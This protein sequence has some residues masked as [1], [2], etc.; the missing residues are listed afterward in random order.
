MLPHLLSEPLRCPELVIAPALG[1]AQSCTSQPLHYQKCVRRLLTED[2]IQIPPEY[3]QL[4]SP[5]LYF[6]SWP[7]QTSRAETLGHQDRH[8]RQA[9][10]LHAST[11]RP[12]T[13]SDPHRRRRPGRILRPERPPWPFPQARRPSLYNC[14]QRPALSSMGFRTNIYPTSIKSRLSSARRHIEAQ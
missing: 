3:H 13:S 6:F 9:Q 12:H 11:T 10:P 7:A 5:Y 1:C 8:I 4:Y 14:S 2:N